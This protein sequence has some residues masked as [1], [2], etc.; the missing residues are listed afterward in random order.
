M[1]IRFA[2]RSLAKNKVFT[3]VA[4]ITLA[5]GIGANTAIFSVVNGILLRALPYKNPDRLFALQEN[6][7]SLARV[8]PVLPVSANHFAEWRRQCTHCEALAALAPASFNLVGDG[9]PERIPGGRVSANYFALLGIQPQ[10]GRFFTDEEDRPGSDK[11][12]I[13]N[14]DLWRRRFASDQSI[15]GKTLRL[16]GVPYTVV[17]VL[18]PTFVAP[19]G[20]ELSPIV[21]FGE[22]TELWKPMA[23]SSDELTSPMGSFNY[24]AIARLKPGATEAQLNAE[25]NTIE[26][27]ISNSIKDEKQRTEMRALVYPLQ[28]EIVGRIRQSL[29]LLMAAVA[30]VLCIVCVNLASLLLARGT[31]RLKELAVRAALGASRL[32]LLRQMVVENLIIAALGGVLGIAVAYLALRVMLLNAPHD[33]PRLESIRIDSYVLLFTIATAAA[34]SFLFGLVPAWK[35]SHADPQNGLRG[36]R[37]STDGPA[38]GRLRSF[39]VTLEVAMSVTLLIAAGLLLSSFARIM[40]IDKGFNDAGGVAVDIAL[41][42]GPYLDATRRAVFLTEILERLKAVPGISSVG[43]TS[44]LPLAGHGEVNSLIPEGTNPSISEM[45]VSDYRYINPDYFQTIGIPLMQ[46]RNFSDA[47]RSRKV[48][49]ISS[50]TATKLWPSQ[51]AIGK[52]FGSDMSHPENLF[53]VVG[54]VGDVHVSSLQESSSGQTLMAYLPYWEGRSSRSFS[55]VLRASI[56]TDRLTAAVREAIWK[57]DPDLPVPEFKTLTRL[58]SD[59]VASQRFQLILI[60]GFAGAAIALAAAGVYGVIAYSVAQRRNEFG[61]RMALGASGWGVT[62]LVVRNGLKLVVAGLITGILGAVALSRLLSGLLFD[63][64]IT[65]PLTYAAVSLLVLLTGAAACYVPARS[66]VSTDPASVLRAN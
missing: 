28:S 18:P 31:G 23:F 59:T 11:V 20:Y 15:I 14:N 51:N 3:A 33:L 55:L 56:P 30:A 36:G 61:I 64:S 39:L 48:A 22:R 29:V 2:L 49:I 9:A 19:K 7:P 62:S 12:V 43:L 53:E 10:L 1:D 44:I 6:I 45:P 27:G 41:P 21:G 26:A 5:L 32:R 50:R 25:L 58:V 63:V 4:I 35:A 8:A 65:D 47:D 17:G 54:V 40:R 52:R 16:D 60:I 46:G 34:A 38:G 37:G 42:R 66:A 24:A 13:I 57:S